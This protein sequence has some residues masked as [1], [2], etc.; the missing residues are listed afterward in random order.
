MNTSEQQNRFTKYT[1][2]LYPIL[3]TCIEEAREQ[4]AQKGF[5]LSTAGQRFTGERTLRTGDFSDRK[6]LEHVVVVR[7]TA[8]TPGVTAI[9]HLDDFLFFLAHRKVWEE[10][11]EECEKKGFCF[12]ESEL[13][14]A[15]ENPLGGIPAKYWVI[16]YDPPFAQEK[17]FL[18]RRRPCFNEEY[19][20]SRD[21]YATHG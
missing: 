4:F 17:Q 12:D 11:K 10:F 3:D 6:R 21:H 14:R 16:L 7:H 1:S 2:Q 8:G 15:M 18:W 20:F 5:T 13:L 9:V 19:C